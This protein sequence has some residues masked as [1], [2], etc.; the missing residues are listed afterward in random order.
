MLKVVAVV[1]PVEV[2]AV[3]Q[4]EVL[5]VVVKSQAVVVVHS[6]VLKLVQYPMLERTNSQLEV[7][8]IH[9]EAMDHTPKHL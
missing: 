7:P 2:K 4:E 3:L 1:V 6:L 9:E 5:L 8:G